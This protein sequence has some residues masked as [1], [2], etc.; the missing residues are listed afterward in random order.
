MALSYLKPSKLLQWHQV[1]TLVNN[2][3]FKS[4]DCNKKIQIEKDKKSQSSLTSWF[5][6]VEKRKASDEEDEETKRKCNKK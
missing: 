5:T 1:S 3:R 4:N 2:S 6:K